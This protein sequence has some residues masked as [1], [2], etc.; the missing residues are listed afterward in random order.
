MQLIRAARRTRSTVQH[1]HRTV[2]KV[3]AGVAVVAPGTDFNHVPADLIHQAIKK[4]ITCSRW[5][6]PQYATSR[7]AHVHT[8]ICMP[9]YV[10]RHEVAIVIG[11]AVVNVVQHLQRV[12]VADAAVEAVASA[13]T[14]TRFA[15]LCVGA[16]AGAVRS[17][18]LYF[19]AAH[20][21]QPPISNDV[22]T[23]TYR[24]GKQKRFLKKVAFV[25]HNSIVS[26]S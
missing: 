20:P 23:C 6:S 12:A 1:S 9:A 16:Q 3:G 21:P 17:E 14:S 18:A 5:S 25:Q 7:I 13:V 22:S 2:S 10:A 8:L 4:A 15:A 19:K 26:I 11:D 24:F